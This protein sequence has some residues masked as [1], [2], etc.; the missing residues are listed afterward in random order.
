MGP[1]QGGRAFSFLWDEASFVTPFSHALYLPHGPEDSSLAELFSSS[2]LLC[3][4]GDYL[5]S[6]LNL[7][8][9]KDGVWSLAP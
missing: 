2:L 1:K 4:I 7:Y 6:S 8:H 5:H 3:W 9:L